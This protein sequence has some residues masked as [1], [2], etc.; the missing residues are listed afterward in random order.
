MFN[1]KSICSTESK[2]CFVHIHKKYP[3]LSLPSI[4]TALSKSYQDTQTAALFVHHFAGRR[5]RGR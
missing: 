1:I 2:V 5:W 3:E 4:S